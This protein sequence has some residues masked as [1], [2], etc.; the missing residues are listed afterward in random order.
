MR[1]AVIYGRE[2]V[3]QGSPYTFL[4]YRSAFKGDLFNDLVDVYEHGRPEMSAMLQF[5]WAMARTHDD[6]VSDYPDWLREFDPRSFALGDADALG[7]IDSAISA[8][9]F[10]RRKAGRARRWIA[11]RVD[12]MAKRLG[13]RAARLL[14]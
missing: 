8:E 4:V 1:R 10:R 11:G 7:V 2:I 3:M 14:G 13:A 9:L 12:A 6:A 5:A